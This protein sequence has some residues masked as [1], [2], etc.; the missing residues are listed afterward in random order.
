VPEVA[1]SWNNRF[2]SF[3]TDIIYTANVPIKKELSGQITRKSLGVGVE[4][5]TQ[6]SRDKDLRKRL[7]GWRK[8]RGIGAFLL[9]LKV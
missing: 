9:N 7:L 1:Q 2:S 3:L 8:L 6:L 5:E 4:D